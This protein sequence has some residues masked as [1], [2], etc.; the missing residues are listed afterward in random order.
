VVAMAGVTTL[1]QTIHTVFWEVIRR[2]F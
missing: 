2:G 1:G